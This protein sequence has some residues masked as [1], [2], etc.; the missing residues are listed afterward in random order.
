MAKVP[1]DGTDSQFSIQSDVIDK[2]GYAVHVF[3]V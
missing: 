1:I 2:N 3:E